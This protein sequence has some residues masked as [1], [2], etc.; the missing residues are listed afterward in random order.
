MLL[1]TI[2]QE[3]NRYNIRLPTLAVTHFIDKR[4]KIIKHDAKLFKLESSL[5]FSKI[6]GKMIK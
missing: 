5:V 4:Q 3:N 6:K 1:I 2:E